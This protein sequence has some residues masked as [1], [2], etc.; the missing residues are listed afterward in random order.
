[1]KTNIIKDHVI[2]SND[3]FLIPNT[4]SKNSKI[5]SGTLN[6]KNTFSQKQEDSP[7]DTKNRNIK[8]K[9]QQE[10]EE[11]VQYKQ[12]LIDECEV[13]K[14]ENEELTQKLEQ[15]IFA[16][17][18]RL[19][20]ESEQKQKEIIDHAEQL[21]EEKLAKTSKEIEKLQLDFEEAKE[22]RLAEWKDDL[23]SE[24]RD[25]VRKNY[26]K[27]IM[28]QIE[29]LTIVSQNCIEQKQK[30]IK[31]TKEELVNLI[32]LISQKVIKKIS[33]ENKEIIIE[34]LESALKKVQRRTELIIRANP[35]QFSF[36]QEYRDSICQNN[37]S[38]ITN[39]K[40]VSDPTVDFGG[41]ILETNFGTIDAGIYSQFKKIEYAIKELEV[42]N[43][44]K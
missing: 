29:F 24:I 35:E 44:P 17:N 9:L 21:A 10:I 15:E 34:N 4:F 18:K 28:E 23:Y 30:I 13:K 12:K 32:L 40:L 2:I 41:C 14:K 25:E 11:L 31:D 43:K 26:E 3:D 39:L 7:L 6:K 22:R 1:M 20:V 38:L 8:E 16:N 37:K 19:Q 27:K 36:L 5:D 33:E 42:L